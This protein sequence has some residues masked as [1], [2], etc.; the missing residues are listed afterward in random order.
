[1]VTGDVMA[2]ESKTPAFKQEA[3][4]SIVMNVSGILSDPLLA[5]ASTALVV[6][7][8]RG[9]RNLVNLLLAHGADVNLGDRHGKTPLTWAVKLGLHEI[10][11]TLRE[12]NS[13]EPPF[14]EGSAIAAL[15]AAAARGDVD[16]TQRLLTHG[17]TAD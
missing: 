1:N 3:D 17:A 7:V 2:G 13:V 9:D 5:Q 12:A 11:Q 8:R 6:A 14:L 10:A 4:A 16:E 15:H